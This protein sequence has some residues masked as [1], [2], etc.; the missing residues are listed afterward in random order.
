MRMR[1]TPDR[2]GD[3]SKGKG[4]SAAERDAVDDGGH[5]V[6]TANA[7]KDSKIIA[8]D[9]EAI[10]K[11]FDIVL[12]LHGSRIAYV[13]VSS[14]GIGEMLCAIPWNAMKYDADG[15]CFHLDVTA[16]HVNAT[17]GFDD[18][19]R[20]AMTPSPWGLSIH[21]YYNRTPYWIE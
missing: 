1:H 20:P 6:T 21:Q 10:G 8:S 16:A 19:H 18:E 4:G 5:V 9:G 13:V 2:S 14:G 3:D 11:V 15:K 17:P 7:L 12:D